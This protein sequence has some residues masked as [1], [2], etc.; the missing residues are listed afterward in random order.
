M[1]ELNCIGCYV[2]G[3]LLLYGGGPSAAIVRVNALSVLLQRISL[4]CDDKWAALGILIH[5]NH[6][7]SWFERIIVA[8]LGR[9][10]IS[11]TL[12]RHADAVNLTNPVCLARNL[13]LSIWVDDRWL[14]QP[15]IGNRVAWMARWDLISVFHCVSSRVLLQGRYSF[16]WPELDVINLEVRV[17]H[18]DFVTTNGDF[19]NVSVSCNCRLAPACV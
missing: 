9:T 12:F 7:A 14:A 18:A 2:F 1:R 19:V 5:L 3:N 11:H 17:A 13:M 8:F 10:W 6:L 15:D 16:V 4:W